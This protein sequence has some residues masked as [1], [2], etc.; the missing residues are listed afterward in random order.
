[1]LLK[2]P[3][4][5]LPLPSKGTISSTSSNSSRRIGNI[6]INGEVVVVEVVVAD[7]RNATGVDKDVAKW[8]PSNTLEG[9]K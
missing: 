1:M 9:I 5:F 7:A 8:H 3:K 6:T 4:S 2:P